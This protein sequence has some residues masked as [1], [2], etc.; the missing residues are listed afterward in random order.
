[1]AFSADYF[2]DYGYN[3][4]SELTSSDRKLDTPTS[5]GADA[6]EDYAYVYD[7]IGN[8]DT[9]ERSS[10]DPT[11][12]ETDTEYAANA[13][14]QYD[15]L[16]VEVDSSFSFRKWYEYD[17]DGNPIASTFVGDMNCD[18]V[19]NFG[20]TDPFVMALTNP[21]LYEATYPDCDIMHGDIN[22][23]GVVNFGDM[24]GYVALITGGGSPFTAE[25]FVYDAENRLIEY[26]PTTPGADDLKVTFGY[27]YL[28]RRVRKQV[29]EYDNSAWS[30]TADVKFVYDGWRPLLELDGLNS[31]A[32]IRKYTWGLDLS[33]SLEGAGGIGGLLAVSDADDPGDPTDQSGNFVF[34][35]DGNGNVGQVVN[36]SADA[37]SPSQALVARYEYAPYGN[38]IES[39]G[40]YADENPMRFSTKYWDDETGLG[41]WG[42]R[43]Y[44]PRLGRW[45]NRDP[46]GEA[47]GL[48]LIAYVQNS[49]VSV[50][51]AIGRFG[52]GNVPAVVPT[53][54]VIP[55]IPG[56]PTDE[57]LKEWYELQKCKA[58]AARVGAWQ[59]LTG[60]GPGKDAN[61]LLDDWSDPNADSAGCRKDAMQHCLGAALLAKECGARCAETIGRWL[62]D[63]Q[64]N[65]S[66][67]DLHNNYVGAFK[68]GSA[69]DVVKCC[70]GQLDAGELETDLDDSDKEY[71]NDCDCH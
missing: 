46:I 65:P 51:D 56:L 67:R 63:D 23:D 33:R 62:E 7:N 28:G 34:C 45:L 3:A 57:Q 15:D 13:L 40:D 20:D 24:D 11:P 16:V 41:Y 25:T 26:R 64:G 10:G 19:V 9:A 50:V 58:C 69:S 4:R 38:V 47:G 36:W 70:A 71:E 21:T 30:Q 12:T 2:E 61:K 44:D 43:Y 37:A 14:N 18:G 8:R 6:N 53:W 27:D 59:W 52:F 48:H 39:D 35:Y 29:Y 31:D 32:V 17:E 5:P 54:R 66:T 42:Y 49:P 22:G 68:C 60:E 1:M 55:P